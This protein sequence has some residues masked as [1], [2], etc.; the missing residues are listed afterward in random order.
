M[1]RRVCSLFVLLVCS[2]VDAKDINVI[3]QKRIVGG[4]AA[5]QPP[6]DDPVVF[7]NKNDQ[8]ARIIGS[9]DP[10]KGFYTFRGIR[11]AEPPTGQNRF[12]VKMFRKYNKIIANKICNIF[13]SSLFNIINNFYLVCVYHI[14]CNV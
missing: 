14:E 10:D 4:I 12:Q 13:L 11:F 6:E 5:A 1:D 2:L 9:R 7:V 8:H 3:R